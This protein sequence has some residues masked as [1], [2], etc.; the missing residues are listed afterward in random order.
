MA[1]TK[2]GGSTRQKGNR[3]GKHLGVKIFGDQKAINGNIIIRQKGST[4][5]AG[6]GV[7]QS[8]DFTLYAIK[9]GMVDFITKH[10]K[11]FVQIVSK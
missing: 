2:A 4:F 5:H 6:E 8:R 1:H 9:D 11:K 3:R 7:R 10:G